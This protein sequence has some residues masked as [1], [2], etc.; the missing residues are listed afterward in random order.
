MNAATTPGTS[1]TTSATRLR[2]DVVERRCHELGAKNDTER[3][4]LLGVNR[5]TVLRWRHGWTG[6]NLSTAQH[7]AKVLSVRLDQL[8]E[9]TDA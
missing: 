9:A 4:D 3:G 8:V 5:N 6:V 7:V 2:W 1:H